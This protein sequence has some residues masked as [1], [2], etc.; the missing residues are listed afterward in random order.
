MKKMPLLVMVSAAAFTLAAC[1]NQPTQ[2]SQYPSQGYPAQAQPS[3]NVY[4]GTVERIEL[5]NRNDPNNIAGTV[6][7]GIVGGLIGHQLGGG[8]GQTAAT[9][10]GAAG[11]AYAGNQIQ[12]RRRASNESFRV[13]VRMNNGTVQTITTDNVTD[14]QTGDRVRVDGNNISRY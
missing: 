14:L 3:R 7:G 1:T 10:V 6:I 4:V 2:Q 5:V 8:R 9:I 12:Q 13:T 11:G